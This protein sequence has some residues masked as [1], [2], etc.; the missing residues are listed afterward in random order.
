MVI[1]YSIQF[2]ASGK[3]DK[4]RSQEL[5]EKICQSITLITDPIQKEIIEEVIQEQPNYINTMKNNGTHGTYLELAV[6]GNMVDIGI[7]IYFKD[8]R[9]TNRI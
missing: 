5:R 3:L 8:D 2:L 7:Q 6:F 1:A 9:Y 4:N